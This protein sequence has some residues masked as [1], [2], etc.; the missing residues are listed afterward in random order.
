MPDA[1][2]LDPLHTHLWALRAAV[3]SEM[4]RLT[5]IHRG[6]SHLPPVEHP[7]REVELTRLI[8]DLAMVTTATDLLRTLSQRALDEARGLR[9]G[10]A[11]DAGR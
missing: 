1:D 2:D 6:L 5:E 8:S 10:A 7:D 9:R 11:H 4:R 3:E